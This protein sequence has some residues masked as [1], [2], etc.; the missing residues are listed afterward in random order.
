ML[1]QL[2]E[3]GRTPETEYCDG[4]Y[5]RDENVVEA[6]RREVDL[7][8]PVAGQPPQNPDD[9]TVDDFVIDET[10]ETVERCPAGCQPESSVHDAESGST[11]TVMRASDC[12]SCAFRLQCPVRP[13]GRRYVLDHTPRQRRLAARRAEQATD[14]FADRYRIRAGGESVNG[15]LKRRTGMGRLRTRG[16]PRVR[17]SVL[18]RCAGWNVFRALS[19]LKKRGIRDFASL[20]AAFWRIVRHFRRR[21]ELFGVP[22]AAQWPT[23]RQSPLAAIPVAA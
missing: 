12:G 10:T 9:L 4:G 19:A 11:R 22:S 15:G 2:D 6:E 8:S 20:L 5:G 7:Q 23:N 13:S 3:H 18:F 14:V 16:H 21:Q 1:D 17:M